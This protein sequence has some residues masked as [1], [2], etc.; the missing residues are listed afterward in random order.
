M[1]VRPLEGSLNPIINELEADLKRNQN[2]KESDISRKVES[3]GRISLL[4]RKKFNKIEEADNNCKFISHKDHD[5]F[6]MSIPNDFLGIVKKVTVNMPGNIYE[7]NI[8]GF[9]GKSIIWDR[10][11]FSGNKIIIKSKKS[12]PLQ[13]TIII[14]LIFIACAIGFVS[15]F[16]FMKIRKPKIGVSGFNLCPECR[17]KVSSSDKFCQN[18]GQS[19]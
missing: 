3:D 14:L 10:T 5:E 17:T 16:Y 19:L 7:S 6:I 18:C 11:I 13:E 4:T 1:K 8:Q 9:N 12:S 2:Y 15:I